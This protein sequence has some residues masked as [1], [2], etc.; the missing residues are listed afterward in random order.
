ME[1]KKTGQSKVAGGV[2]PT[3]QELPDF[4]PDFSH[5]NP[6]N[7]RAAEARGLKF[8]PNGQCYRN[9]DG[10]QVRDRFGQPL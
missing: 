9:A 2:N 5:N 1:D 4:D 8:D 3:P 10:D 7:Q 6:Q